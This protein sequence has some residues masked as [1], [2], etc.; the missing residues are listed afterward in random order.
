MKPSRIAEARVEE[1]IV[2]LFQDLP[3][4][5]GFTVQARGEI[6]LTDIG[7]YP[8]PPSEDA[9]LICE[10]IHDALAALVEERPEARDLIAGRTFA[11]ALH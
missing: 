3:A 7:F 9:K 4:L 11:R 10:E 2:A 8:P 6:E 5:C 1:S